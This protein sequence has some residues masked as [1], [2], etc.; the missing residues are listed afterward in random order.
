MGYQLETPIFSSS[1]AISSGRSH[2]SS[3]SRRTAPLARDLRTSSTTLAKTEPLT[4]GTAGMGLPPQVLSAVDLFSLSRALRARKQPQNSLKS[5]APRSPTRLKTAASPLTVWWRPARVGTPWRGGLFTREDVRSSLRS[6]GA[7]SV[8]MN[9]APSP[10]RG[11]H[12][13]HEKVGREDICDR[14][15]PGR[16]VEERAQELAIPNRDVLAVVHGPDRRDRDESEE[17]AP[18]EIEQ[19]APQNLS[20]GRRQGHSGGSA[21]PV[22]GRVGVGW[23]RSWVSRCFASATSSSAARR[24]CAGWSV[25]ITSTPQSIACRKTGTVSGEPSE[26]KNT[27]TPRAWLCSTS[28]FERSRQ[29][30]ST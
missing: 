26:S 25:S 7:S 8:G 29:G 23:S 18:Q 11:S 19:L 6:G 14:G 20:G 13:L 22:C 16:S 2:R 24:T 9:P 15:E 10:H 27:R 17:D 28:S 1:R 3:W 5:R 12:E 30:A 21:L 4:E